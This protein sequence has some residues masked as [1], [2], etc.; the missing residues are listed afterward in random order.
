L[1]FGYSDCTSFPQKTILP[2]LLLSGDP[3]TLFKEK[4]AYCSSIFLAS[5]RPLGTLLVYPPPGPVKAR[6]ETVD[7]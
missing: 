5:S 2:V 4:R 6:C 1:L 7:A 3:L